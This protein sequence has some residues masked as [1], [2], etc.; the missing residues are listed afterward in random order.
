MSY[1]TKNLPALP[2]AANTLPALL[3]RAKAAIA[4]AIGKTPEE[5]KA[6]AASTADITKITNAD[7]REQVH[8]AMMALKRVRVDIE[9]ICK[10][11]RDLA[12]KF[13]K[14]VIEE[15]NTLVALTSKEEDRLEKLR[16]DWDE[17]REKEKQAKID[18]E[19][20]RVAALNERIVELR[21]NQRITSLDSPDFIAEHIG[22]LE[23]IPVDDSF[24]ELKQQ[25]DD[26]KTA[27]LTRLR[28]LLKAATARVEDEKR[29]AAERAELA[30]L[31]AEALERE[32]VER[33]RI[34]EEERKAKAERDA[35]AARQ[36]AALRME[37]EELDR[38]EAERAKAAKIEAD[39][40]AAEKAEFEKA[41]RIAREQKEAEEK[42]KAEQ[43]RIASVQRPTDDELVAVLAKHYNVPSKKVC[44]WL[45]TYRHQEAA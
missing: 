2:E 45:S 21:G 8:A 40:L 9:K 42:L 7:G 31:R 37:R 34:A 15:E 33:E 4:L 24:A 6:L 17:A 41:Q 30:K 12:T 43:A 35:E 5:L 14:A 16:D 28:E 38:K 3:S 1:E 18:A 32:R 27:G 25:A 26:A 36:A 22:D 29:I 23:A 10:A 44:E 13:S 19:I 39:K 20:A 11:E